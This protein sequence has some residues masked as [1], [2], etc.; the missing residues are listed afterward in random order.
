MPRESCWF[1]GAPPDVRRVVG[2]PGTD[3]RICDECVAT[4]SDLVTLEIG[5]VKDD[6]I[7]REQAERRAL[8]R[9]MP[10]FRKLAPE[11]QAE[12]LRAGREPN[13][14]ATTPVP[15]YTCSFCGKKRS[16]VGHLVVGPRVFIC[17]G[18][19]AAAAAALS[20]G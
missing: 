3:A 6:P 18:C 8:E 1:C 10:G 19:A 14:G 17:G 16:E 13:P 7:L 5:D 15:D 4:C 12:L 2:L 9:I 20:S 11:A